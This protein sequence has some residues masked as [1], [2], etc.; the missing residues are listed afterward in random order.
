MGKGRKMA[1]HTALLGKP[2]GKATNAPRLKE[3]GPT[4][5]SMRDYGRRNRLVMGHARKKE[6]GQTGCAPRKHERKKQQPIA[7]GHVRAERRKGSRPGELAPA[8]CG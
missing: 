8:T 5:R 2:K 7:W 4:C 3:K 6:N 1:G